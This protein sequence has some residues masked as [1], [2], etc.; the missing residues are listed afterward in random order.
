MLY[1]LTLK[2][3]KPILELYKT[4]IP[5]NKLKIEEKHH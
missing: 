4:L 2:S 3:L 5:Y 1:S